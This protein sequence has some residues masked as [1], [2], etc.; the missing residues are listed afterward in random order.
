MATSSAH[1]S[2]SE[3]AEQVPSW[4]LDPEHTEASFRARR[5]GAT[6][7]DGHF[8]E[9][10]GKLYWNLED[11]LS[12]SCVGEIDV[13]KLYAGEPYL[14]TQLRA[15]DFLDASHHRTIVFSARLADRTAEN[16]FKAEV[17]LTLR[18][19]TRKVIMDL[20]YL[21]QWEAPV[22]MDGQNRGTA[23]RVGLRAEGIITRRDFEDGEQEHTDEEDRSNAGG[24]PANAIEIALD[25]EAVLDDDLRDAGASA[26]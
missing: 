16:D 22:W 19:A 14:N 20:T 11:P 6:W 13:T 2:S 5:M 12:G 1:P 8:K 17:L 7:V 25:V 15:A 3:A 4:T 10:H 21:G 24:L 9:V 18:G 26:L 23:T